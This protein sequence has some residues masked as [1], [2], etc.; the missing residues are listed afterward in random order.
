MDVIMYPFAVDGTATRVIEAGSGAK[1]VVFIHGLGARADRWVANIAAIAEAGYHCY[2]ID[3]PGHGFA[4]KAADYPYGV[5]AFAKF[6]EGF[7]DG[8][9]IER[10]TVVGTSLGG[11]VGAFFA[12]DNPD[13]VRA[14]VLVGSVGV[15]PLGREAAEAVR[16]NVK[17]TTREGT[18]AKLKFVFAKHE[19]ITDALIDEEVRVNTSPGAAKAFEVLGDYIAEKIDWDNIGDRLAEFARTKPV[20]LVWGEEDQA[21]PLGIGLKVQQK[22]K[23]ADLVRMPGCG[24]VCYLEDEIMFNQSVLEFMNGVAE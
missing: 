10:A 20:L 1:S 7:L 6:V 15:I 12:C 2:A 22:I 3:L 19:M 11:H 9:E 5:P 23:N 18:E 13:R 16:V 17:N 14:L 21:V 4:D 24:H 8:M